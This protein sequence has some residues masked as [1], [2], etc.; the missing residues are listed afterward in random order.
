MALRKDGVLSYLVPDLLGSVSLTLYADGSTESVQLYG[1]FGATRYSDGATPTVYGFTGQRTDST[2]GLMYYGA[3]YYDPMSGRFISADGVESNASGDDPYAYVGENPETETDPTGHMRIDQQGDRSWTSPIGNK[4]TY[5]DN[6]YT[7]GPSIIIGYGWGSS[8][9]PYYGPIRQLWSAPVSHPAPARSKP[10][11]QPKR[12]PAKAAVALSPG[13]IKLGV[14]LI[15]N[16]KTLKDDFHSEDW[17]DSAKVKFGGPVKNDIS[18]GVFTDRYYFTLDDGEGSHVVL[19][20]NYNPQ[21]ASDKS[22]DPWD[23]KHV[24]FS[25]D[26]VDPEKWGE[27]GYMREEADPGSNPNPPQDNEFDQFFKDLPEE[28]ESAGFA[29][30]LE[31]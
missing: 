7:P 9:T 13:L 16:D 1:P 5:V 27:D 11:A 8:W 25:S 30:D 19:S 24:H 23:M 3:R 2:T 31:E 15:K 17:G 14:K 12:S 20:L 6:D 10:K 22:L 4:A 26:Q 28:I 21:S 18:G 29:A